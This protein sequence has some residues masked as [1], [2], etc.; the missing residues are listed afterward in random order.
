LIRIFQGTNNHNFMNKKRSFRIFIT[1]LLIVLAVGVLIYVL[2]H[3]DRLVLKTYLNETNGYS[4]N[5]P[6]TWVEGDIRP[7]GND[8]DL[9]LP[10]ELSCT[11][12]VSNSADLKW[13]GLDCKI[14]A[15]IY[16]ASFEKDIFIATGSAVPE[17]FDEYIGLVVENGERDLFGYV[18]TAV[19]NFDILEHRGARMSAYLKEGTSRKEQLMIELS[20]DTVLSI[21]I[22]YL[23]QY[24]SQALSAF[25]R[26]ISTLRLE[27]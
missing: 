2:S 15:K 7:Y 10:P 17:S 8:T 12:T 21:D 5:Y 26:V 16:V 24:E 1:V 3:K 9:V 18:Y 6:G 13:P 27:K 20:A 11:E 22:D 19:N 23:P 4:F 25:E 14:P